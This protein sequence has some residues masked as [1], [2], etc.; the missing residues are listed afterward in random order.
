[1]IDQHADKIPRMNRLMQL[2]EAKGCKP[3]AGFAGD[4]DED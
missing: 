2:S 4:D 1:V 3:P